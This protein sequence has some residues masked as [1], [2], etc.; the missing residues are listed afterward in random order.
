MGCTVNC[1]LCGH[2]LP[3]NAHGFDQN[4]YFFD[5][6]LDQMVHSGHCT[7][8]KECNPWLILA[9]NFIDDRGTIRRRDKTY[10]P[11]DE[12]FKT[13]DYFCDEWDYD[14]EGM[15]PLDTRTESV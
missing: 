2:T 1:K 15:K 7:Y 11:T 12:E 4:D 9:R 6:D 13:I 5:S 3:G 8:C 14:W 10:Q